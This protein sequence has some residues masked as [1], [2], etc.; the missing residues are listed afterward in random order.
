MPGITVYTIAETALSF[1][2]Y[3]ATTMEPPLPLQGLVGPSPGGHTR[4]EPGD[5]LDTPV[6]YV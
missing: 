6:K 5:P 2:L 1:S 4:R 3:G